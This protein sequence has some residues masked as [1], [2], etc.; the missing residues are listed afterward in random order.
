MKYIG[1]QRSVI[2]LDQGR[3]P[4]SGIRFFSLQVEIKSPISYYLGIH[5]IIVYLALLCH[6]P[7]LF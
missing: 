6:A 7:A 5:V 1:F 4:I 3:V 2:S